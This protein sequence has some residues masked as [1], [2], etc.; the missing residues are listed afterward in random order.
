MLDL[1]VQ[2]NER[3][4]DTKFMIAGIGAQLGS[5]VAMATLGAKLRLK[6]QTA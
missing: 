1:E 2:I 3:K 6:K 5:V 4:G